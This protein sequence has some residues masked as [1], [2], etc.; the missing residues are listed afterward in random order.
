MRLRRPWLGLFLP[1]S[2]L[3]LVAACGGDDGDS[4]SSGDG[5]SGGGPIPG[6]DSDGDGIPDTV[7]GEG[8]TDGDGTPD[9]L[10]LDSDNDGIPDEIEAGLTPQN[11]VDS[12]TDGTA[13]FR[14]LD[15]DNNG[16]SDTVEAGANPAA[17]VD[18]NGDGTFDYADFDNDGDGIP[19]GVEI[20]GEDA[21]CDGDGEPDPLSTVEAPKDCDTDGVE[22]FMSSDTD[23]DGISDLVE[24]S[25]DT[26]FDGFLDRYDLD[27]DNDTL[28]DAVEGDEDADGDGIPNFRDPD[29]DDDGLSDQI[30]AEVGTDPLNADSDG[31][32]VS[33]LVEVAA[34]TNPLDAADN[35]QARG[36]FVFILPYQGDT[37]PA[38]DT[39][40]FR[41]NIQ[42]ADVYFAF[43]I[44]NSMEAELLA[45]R[46][47][48]TGIPAIVS[49]LRCA[50]SGVSCANDSECGTNEVCFNNA[51]ITDPGLGD[52][53]VPDLWTGVGRF[54]DLNTYRNLLSLQ[55][56]PVTTANAIPGNIGIGADEAPYQPSHCIANP[57]L[58]PNAT[59]MQ[60]APAGQGVGCPGFRQDAVRIYV[61]ITD[62][63]DQCTGATCAS[64]T[65]N[66]AGQALQTADIKFVGLWGTGDDNGNFGTPFTVARD[67]ALASN[68]VDQNG[69]PFVYEA[70]DAAVVA[71]AVT[72]L[73]RLARGTPLDVTIDAVDDDSDAVDALQFIDHLEVNVSGTGSCT[74]VTMTSDTNGDSFN[75]AFPDLLPGTPVCWD[76][77]PVLTNTTVEPTTEPQLFKASLSVRGDGSPLDDRDVYFLIPPKKV[78]IT[79][80]Q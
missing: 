44:T 22:D 68:S 37:A 29:S 67:I 64:Y 77:H 12:D 55:A 42:Y 45:M 66:S 51:C 18:T 58:C 10:D 35:P 61:Q 47:A 2:A 11:P 23:G 71:N 40:E 59:N 75:D 31:D 25:A 60:C 4:S 73:R 14:D 38:E 9:H 1:L 20:V 41:T 80:P 65:A 74:D 54:S 70:I 15:S 79:P 43:D 56:N 7:E 8:D 33:D 16:I 28:T 53:C 26:D 78:E 46:N 62:A 52:G 36:D 63:D 24:G 72:A 17:P 34:E 27:S 30:E 5:G 76:L 49:Q 13:D 39:L 57:S 3:M 32:G 6:V 50:P 48:T 69:D 21:D 19:D